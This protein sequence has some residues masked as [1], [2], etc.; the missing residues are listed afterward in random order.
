MFTLL[1]LAALSA[2]PSDLPAAPA[3]PVERA[4]IFQAI[5]AVEQDGKWLLCEEDPDAEGVTIEQYRDLNGDGLPDAL[6]TG[7]SSFC[8]G[9]AG[10][11]FDLISQQ[12]DGS[13]KSILSSVGIP[14]ILPTRGKD[15]WPDLAIGGPGSCF[16]VQRWN[17][18]DYVLNRYEYEGEPCTMPRR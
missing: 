4:A 14:Q 5:G 9:L 12:P 2:A 1:F 8:F 13:W 11:G 16:P 18:K 6:V 3:S 17:G 10:A 15:G 7:S